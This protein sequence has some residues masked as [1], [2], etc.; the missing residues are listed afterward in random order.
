MARPQSF[1]S[2][3][4]PRL[5]NNLNALLNPVLPPAS[6]AQTRVTKRGTQVINYSEEFL[7]DDD[8]EDSDGPRKPTG[9][10]SKRD[11]PQ[12]QTRDALVERLSKELKAPVETQG[13]WRDWFAKPNFGKSVRPCD[14][15]V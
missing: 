14:L 10:R 2:E 13:I 4:A 15:R 7:N 5:R 12:D 8:F 11:A 1:L 3:F 9:L 6:S